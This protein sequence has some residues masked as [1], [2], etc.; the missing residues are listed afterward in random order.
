[1]EKLKLV[2]KVFFESVKISLS[3]FILPTGTYLLPAVCISFAILVVTIICKIF[4]LFTLL[5]IPGAALGCAVLLGIC[6]IERKERS[7]ISNIY[8]TVASTVSAVTNRKAR[9]PTSEPAEL[10]G[11]STEVCGYGSDC[12]EDGPGSGV[13]QESSESDENTSERSAV[14]DEAADGQSAGGEPQQWP[15]RGALR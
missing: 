2:L 9:T 5:D 3:T 14:T 11:G 15:Q 4:D 10:D 13:S 6:F 7:E 1:M 8:R 12:G